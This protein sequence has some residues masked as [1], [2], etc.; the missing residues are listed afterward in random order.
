MIPPLQYEI[1][2]ANFLNRGA[3][4]MLA[5]TIAAISDR[6]PDLRP[7]IDLRHTPFK[8]KVRHGL[9][10][11]PPKLLAPRPWTPNFFNRC[12]WRVNEMFANR[13]PASLCECYGI[14]R[15]KDNLAL[16]DVSGYAFGDRWGPGKCNVFYDKALLYRNHQKPVVLLPQ[17]LGP[18]EDEATQAAFIRMLG[19]VDL[20]FARD[21]V[22]YEHAIKLAPEPDR[23]QKVPDITIGFKTLGNDWAKPL[24][25]RVIVVLNEKMV[26]GHLRLS[27][28]QYLAMIESAVGEVMRRGCPV[29]VLVHDSTGGD[30]ALAKELCQRTSELGRVEI[31][32]PEDPL[33][34]KKM[35]GESRFIIA[36]RFHAVVSALSQSI[37]SITLGWAFKYEQLHQ[38]FGV[39]EL[40]VD[41]RSGDVV[42][43]L[44][45][46]VSDCLNRSVHA[47][48]ARRLT[49]RGDVARASIAAMW[50]SLST[51]LSSSNS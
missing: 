41:V 9:R 49:E 35:I 31:V 23:I 2:G 32:H 51:L 45:N 33:K 6:N 16:L 43:E 18:F 42:A 26:D 13:I 36:S 22:S 27:R 21:A 29:S 39:E 47:E 30:L 37:P 3:E 46:R 1:S 38:D 19:V 40:V 8:N 28:D 25:D 7:S 48:L 44:R 17:M 15:P 10:T 14:A 24:G 4:L 20:V 11:F 50:D 12:G 5:T 34:I